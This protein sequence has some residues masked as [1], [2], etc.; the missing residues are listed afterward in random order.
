MEWRSMPDYKG[1]YEVSSEG[2]VRSLYFRPARAVKRIKDSCGYPVVM[3]SKAGKR[4]PKTLHRMVCRAFHGEPEGCLEASHLDGV[5][6]NCRAENL[7]WLTHR[8]NLAHRK[9]HGTLLF[10]EKHPRAKL[11]EDQARTILLSDKRPGEL[12]TEFNVNDATI[13]DIR[14]GKNWAHLKREAGSVRKH[15]SAAIAHPILGTPYEYQ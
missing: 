11:T 15:E 7:Q 10:G 9:E 12:A 5:K 13:R 6:E 4:T 14:L 1:L 2:D 8:E 3:L